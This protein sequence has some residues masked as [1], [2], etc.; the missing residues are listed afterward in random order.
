[1]RKGHGTYNYSNGDRYEG[2]WDKDLQ[3]G[4]GTYYY[5]N[6]DIFKG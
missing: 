6:G 3:N 4:S 5:S 2:E 1:V